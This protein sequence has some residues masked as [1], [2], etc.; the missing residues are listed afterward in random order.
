[1]SDTSR[2]SRFFFVDSILWA[3]VL[4]LLAT[5]AAHAQDAGIPNTLMPQPA[6]LTVGSGSLP[7]TSAL[8]LTLHGGRNPLLQ[9]AAARMLRRL[10]AETA[11]PLQK[12]L[13]AANAVIDV[14][15]EDA[16]ATRPALGVDESYTLD[17][18]SSR[19]LIHA[20]TIFGAIYAFETLLQLVEPQGEDFVVPA[21]HIADAPRFPWRGLLLDPG[22]HF[23]SVDE[24]LRTL[25]G[26]ASVK[27]NVLH[28]HLTEDQGFRIESLRYP[29]L[30]QLGSEGQYYTQQ[31]VREIVRYAA[32]RGIRV[33]PEFD[34]PGHSTT[35]F[36][37]YPELASQPGPYEVSHANGVHDAAMNPA[38]EETYRFLDNFFG[39]MTGLFPDEFIHIGGDE[40][41][42]KH[43]MANP[44]IVRFMK[45]HNLQDTKALQAYFNH[46]VELLLKKHNRQMVGWDEILHADLAPDV[47]V[48]NWH[49]MEFLIDAA[50]QGHRGL[51]S[52]PFYLDHAYSAGQMYAADPQPASAGLSDA[53][54]KLILGGEACMWGELVSNENI[55]S[56]TWPRS[57]A[58]AERFWSPA[59][60][61]DVEDMYRR[62]AVTS[63]RL[64]ALGV[65]HL[66][67]PQRGLRQIAG[68]IEGAS[69]LEQL[70]AVLQP[71]DFH[72]RQ[73]LQHTS[74]LTPLVRF[75][76]YAQ[77]DPPMQDRLR[78]LVEEYLHGANATQRSA[79]GHQLRSIF[80][81][82][83]AVAPAL[84]Q[85]VRNRPLMHEMRTRCEQ[86]PQLGRLGIEAI[87][88]IEAHRTPQP[89]WV[90]DGQ[91]L[92]TQSEQSSGFTDFVVLPQLKMLVD[93]A[94]KP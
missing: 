76:D 3:L 46:R 27:L 36:I 70:Q 38:R 17:S 87:D 31:Q 10:E 79:A 72:P 56:R 78:V 52:Q 51:L 8:S 28:W 94:E 71:V 50:R 61:R 67:G 44:E 4:L 66:S 49:G 32:A 6:T 68:S 54:A 59:A 62:L 58:V 57:A 18:D 41:N 83:I 25:D 34:I 5:Y 92:L 81:S 7:I 29:K 53:E 75:V 82:W 88:D 74:A 23:L 33:L 80:E 24:I 63:L 47:V 48:Q 2:Y 40:S 60:T 1:V 14:K 93:A 43:W 21:V 15:V 37:G 77:F 73:L 69:A 9:D 19:V 26:M 89:A 45:E 11:V 90:K 39:E 91:A 35:W 30:H 42:G 84:E 65:T 20:K 86:L 12:N 13:Q 85:L 22:R 16:S 64:D 55:D